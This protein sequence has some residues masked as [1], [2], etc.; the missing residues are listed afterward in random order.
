VR[1]AAGENENAEKN[2]S[3]AERQVATAPHEEEQRERDG[4]IGDGD[5]QVGGR[6]QPYYRPIAQT[7][8][9]RHEIRAEQLFKKR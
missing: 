8:D 9:M 7:I 3:P 5:R 4:E 1:R 6:V 2:V